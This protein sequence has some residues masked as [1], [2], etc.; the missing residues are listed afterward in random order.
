MLEYQG[1]NKF[2]VQK[3]QHVSHFLPISKFQ[4]ELGPRYIQHESHAGQTSYYFLLK[5][6]FS[7]SHKCLFCRSPLQVGLVSCQGSASWLNPLLSSVLPLPSLSTFATSTLCS[8]NCCP[9]PPS[10]CISAP[11]RPSTGPDVVEINSP[12]HLTSPF[13]YTRL[14]QSSP[15]P[16]TQFCNHSDD[17]SK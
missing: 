14:Q 5:E 12:L 2:S 1:R 8:Q 17:K 4:K 10:P 16:G 11:A 3:H 13:S 15:L 9:L 7:V 6:T